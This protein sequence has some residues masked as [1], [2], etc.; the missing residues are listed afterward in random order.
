MTEAY[1]IRQKCLTV[2]LP[3][4]VK[5]IHCTEDARNLL[6]FSIPWQKPSSDGLMEGM[7]DEHWLLWQAEQP[8]EDNHHRIIG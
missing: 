5:C 6:H 4:I 1:H 8:A 2:V 3:K 7:M